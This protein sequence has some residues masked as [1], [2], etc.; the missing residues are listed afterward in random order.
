[1]LDQFHKRKESYLYKAFRTELASIIGTHL[2]LLINETPLNK[3]EI[4]VLYN[5]IKE[6]VKNA[7]IEPEN[8]NLFDVFFGLQDFI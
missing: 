2:V 5:E 8:Y 4:N 3:E 1:M 6:I 7:K